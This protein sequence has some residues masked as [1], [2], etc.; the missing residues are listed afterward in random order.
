MITTNAIIMNIDWEI[1]NDN[2]K[3]GYFVTHI[4]FFVQILVIRTM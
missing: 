1:V 2:Q 4:E 3:M